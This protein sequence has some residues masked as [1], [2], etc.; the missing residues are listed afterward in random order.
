MT[1][2][3]PSVRPQATAERPREQLPATGTNARNGE[4][5]R[6][7]LRGW[8]RT[9]G[10]FAPLPIGY[11]AFQAVLSSLPPMSYTGIHYLCAVACGIAV[12]GVAGCAVLWAR[13]SP[14][15][16]STP[17]PAPQPQEQIHG[18]ARGENALALFRAS[19]QNL[20][21]TLVTVEDPT[22]GRLTGWPHFFHE[23][24]A[25]LRPTP[26]GTAY[27]L[28]LATTLD[29]QDG[30]L[31]R[32]ALAETLWRLRR[33][34]GGWASRSQGKVGRPEVT[35]LVLGALT[36]AGCD[37]S[38]LERAGDL[39][40]SMITSETDIAAT[41]STFIVCTL[42]RELARV[43]PRSPLLQH[44]RT[45]LLAGAIQDPR[46]DNLLCW[47]SRLDAGNSQ[48]AVPSPAH[49]ALAVVA[50]ARAR[51]VI[52]DGGQS[53]SALSQA[54]RWLAANRSLA[55]QTTQI[56]RFTTEEHAESLNV[57]LFTAAWVARALLAV[58]TD[59]IRG[60][61]SLLEEAIARVVEAQHDGV[62]E[63]ESDRPVW[64][65]YQGVS[66]LHAYALRRWVP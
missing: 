48:V 43:R 1:G 16:S 41:T 20:L 44:L 8:L 51:Q 21:A 62:W 49:T 23:A 29:D 57:S 42:V 25:G 18:P 50:L 60:A 12:A 22:L 34:D 55:N 61:D 45:T 46:H 59:D 38:R 13:R 11:G 5:A 63:W 40:E 7:R 3:L 2:R 37:F 10:A 32:A 47:P 39:F 24:A 64:M 52:G 4:S 30:R 36:T 9:V 58:G 26:Y 35:A 56:R 53:Q 27:G 31:D 15:E 65:T 28:K 66:T 14:A 17:A 6:P 54:V 19:Y 33:S